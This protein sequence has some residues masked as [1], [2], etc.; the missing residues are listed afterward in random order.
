MGFDPWN[1]PLK[2]QESTGTPT[3]KMGAHL[4]VWVFILTLSHTPGSMRCDSQ[5]SLLAHA[6]ASPCFGHEPKTMVMIIDPVFIEELEEDET[7]E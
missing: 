2:I 3:P 4:G 1:R 5:A 7:M 6:L